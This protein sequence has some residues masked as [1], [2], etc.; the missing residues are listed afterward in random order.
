VPL[1]YTGNDRN[2]GSGDVGS[3]PSDILSIKATS[4]NIRIAA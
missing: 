3:T 2:S 4:G 1:A